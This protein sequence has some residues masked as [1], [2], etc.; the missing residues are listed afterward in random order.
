MERKPKLKGKELVCQ[1]TTQS[2]IVFLAADKEHIHHLLMFF[3]TT[4]IRLKDHLEGS[5]TVQRFLCVAWM[6][7]KDVITELLPCI[8]KFML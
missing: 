3:L 6:R 7:I 1:L 5:A 4:Q 8:V 2:S